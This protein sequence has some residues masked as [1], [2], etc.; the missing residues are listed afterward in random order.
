LHLGL[1][2]QL[3][4][5]LGHLVLLENPEVLEFLLHL[6]NLRLLEHLSVLRLLEHL[7]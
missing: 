1:L 3:L 5:H 7:Y 4:G 2:G 6:E